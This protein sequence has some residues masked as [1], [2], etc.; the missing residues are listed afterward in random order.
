MQ[1][2]PLNYQ[3][4]LMKVSYVFISLDR[5]MFLLVP[6]CG[7]K[8]CCL[9]LQK[10]TYF[11]NMRHFADKNQSTAR[12]ATV[13]DETLADVEPCRVE[14]RGIENWLE[15]LIESNGDF[16]EEVEAT[17]AVAASECELRERLQLAVVIE[18]A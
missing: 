14:Q 3:C 2:E 18:D 11:L 8:P 4:S 12:V 1:R 17:A 6:R 10:Y 13:Q 15:V 5:V 16:S 9:T 7:A